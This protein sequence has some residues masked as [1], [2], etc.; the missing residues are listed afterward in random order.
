[1][2]VTAGNIA[3]F[4]KR[5]MVPPVEHDMV[6]QRLRLKGD[7]P[8][9]PWLHAA[10]WVSVLSVIAF[11]ET[12][13]VP[14]AETRDW[15]WMSFGL[16]SPIVGFFSVW[17]L[18]YGSS[19]QSK[20]VAIWLRTLADLGVVFTIGLY[21]L[22]TIVEG[23]YRSRLANTVL[24]FAAAYMFLLVWRDLRLVVRVEKLASDIHAKYL[25]R[26]ADAT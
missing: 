15:V 22:T 12:G 11:G 7:P 21:Q 6:E 20:Y 26:G 2:R 19:G 14:P 16:I 17:A 13:I 3:K 23:Q 4:V 24:T 1:M 25:E 8:W 5:L 18:V 9:E 10:V